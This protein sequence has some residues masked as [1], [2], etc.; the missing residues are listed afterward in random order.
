[1]LGPPAAGFAL[2]LPRARPAAQGPKKGTGPGL[3]LAGAEMVRGAKAGEGCVCVPPCETP[4]AA[5]RGGAHPRACSPSS[6]FLLVGLSLC[7]R[8]CLPPLPYPLCAEASPSPQGL[9][10]TA[11]LISKRKR[12]RMVEED[13]G[14]VVVSRG[15]SSFPRVWWRHATRPWTVHRD[16]VETESKQARRKSR[17]RPW[18]QSKGGGAQPLR[19]KKKVARLPK[20]TSA[21]FACSLFVLASASRGVDF[22]FMM[23]MV[24]RNHTRTARRADGDRHTDTLTHSTLAGNP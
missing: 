17:N 12:N 5:Q 15:E 9:A 2:L 10:S 11:L 13:V 8:C 24:K 23:V 18:M 20:Q 3:G 4:D 19:A 22:G 16:V 21:V 1:M 14:V 6:L 7:R